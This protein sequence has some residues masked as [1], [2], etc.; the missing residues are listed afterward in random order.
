MHRVNAIDL[1][2]V[3][4]Q[5][6][7]LIES[8]FQQDVLISKMVTLWDTG[9]FYV[10]W[11]FFQVKGWKHKEKIKIECIYN[12]EDIAFILQNLYNINMQKKKTQTSK[13]E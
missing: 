6:I 10:C 8:H 5:E 11:V 3:A 2:I 4:K 9:D 1:W 13:W 12:D 7:I